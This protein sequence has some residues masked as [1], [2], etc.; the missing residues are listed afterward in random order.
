MEGLL[1]DVTRE[2]LTLA[3][4]FALRASPL[5]HTDNITGC[6]EKRQV[7]MLCFLHE[8]GSWHPRMVAH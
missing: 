2:G 6:F 8:S 1:L 7:A 5:T 3:T 4:D